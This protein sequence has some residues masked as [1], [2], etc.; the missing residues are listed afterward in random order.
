LGIESFIQ[1]LK[2]VAI[3]RWKHLGGSHCFRHITKTP[4][5]WQYRGQILSQNKTVIVEA[6]ITAVNDGPRPE[7]RADGRLSVDG[8]H[9]YQMEN[10]GIRL[11]PV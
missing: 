1:L 9:I 5:T 7:I 3:R 8:L 11:E 10:F 6:M 2:Y 4:H